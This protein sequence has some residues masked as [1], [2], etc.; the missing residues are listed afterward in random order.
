MLALIFIIAVTT[1]SIIVNCQ[2]VSEVTWF[3]AYRG[4]VI[5]L[6]ASGVILEIYTRRKR[7]KEEE[8]EKKKR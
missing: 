2:I 5:G 4:G 7:R 6:F 8:E 1:L 3:D